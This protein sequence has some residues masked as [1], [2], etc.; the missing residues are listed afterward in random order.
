MAD[1][2]LSARK[3]FKRCA[4]AAGS[5]GLRV[6]DPEAG[7]GKPVLEVQRAGLQVAGT[8]GVNEDPGAQ[9]FDHF[10]PGPGGIK[11]HRI[12]QTSAATFL[13]S[14]P[15]P[16]CRRVL[17]DEIEKRIGCRVGHSDHVLFIRT[18]SCEVKCHGKDSFTA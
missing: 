17:T 18:I 3:R 7:A 14:Q 2:L 8:L 16:V 9:M 11:L 6:P 5:C 13:D 10:V 1:L 15:E 12:L 4:A